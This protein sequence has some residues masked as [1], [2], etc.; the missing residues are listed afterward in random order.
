MT[1]F[2]KDVVSVTKGTGLNVGGKIRSGGT[3]VIGQNQNEIGG[4]FLASQAF[5][6]DVTE[7]NVW[8]TTL[9]ENDIAAQA[10]HCHITQGSVS[11]WSQFK[12]D[13]H[14]EVNIAGQLLC[15]L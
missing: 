1:E 15:K 3:T 12:L 13:V 14:G 11:W 8:C 4:G 2:Y 10:N 5:I 9:S 7:V 6:G